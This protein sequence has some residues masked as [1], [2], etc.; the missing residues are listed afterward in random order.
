MNSNTRKR[1]RPKQISPLEVEYLK[2]RDASDTATADAYDVHSAAAG[3]EL[4]TPQSLNTAES[5]HTD[6]WTEEEKE[7][8][9]K[10]LEHGRISAMAITRR[11]GHTKS[12]RQ[13]AQFL[14][15]MEFYATALD[16]PESR[17]KR[18]EY[19][20]NEAS[21]L[22]CAEKVE[23][24]RAALDEAWSEEQDLKR[25]ESQYRGLLQNS[26]RS[27]K[28]AAKKYKVLDHSYSDLLAKIVS[29]NGDATVSTLS[30]M[31]L[32]GYLTEFVR[33]IIKDVI[34]RAKIACQPT[35][36]Y[37]TKIN[38]IDSAYI[39][40]SLA[41]CS[42]K[43]EN[44]PP[45]QVF[46]SLLEKYVDSDSLIDIYG[47]LVEGRH[48]EQI[49]VSS[50][51]IP[52][53]KAPTLPIRHRINSSGSSAL[54]SSDDSFSQLENLPASL[55]AEDDFVVQDDPTYY[56][57]PQHLEEGYNESDDDVENSS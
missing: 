37:G 25:L 13:V 54:N 34:V 2:L 11:L 19:L 20:D 7:K 29:G 51:R 15:H 38:N 44:R 9:F 43:V 42:A 41:A 33:K 46:G 48:H 49:I 26:A 16:S 21:A 23:E 56:C 55:R 22:H 36:R 35:Y 8:I 1:K 30:M 4:N 50:L 24:D 45:K 10:I 17:R 6:T 28:T 31:E 47:S 18:F 3:T 14:D 5:K 27:V 57:D 32:H 40:A 52:P 53:N 39:K 12:L